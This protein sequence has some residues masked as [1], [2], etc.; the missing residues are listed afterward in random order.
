MNKTKIRNISVTAMLTALAFLLTF[1][2]RFK[3]A[4]LT[5]DFKDAIISIASLLFGPLYG[6]A[7]AI[8]VAFIEFISVSDT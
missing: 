1:V 2:F 6:V 8:I 3:V 7:S 5:F 4:F